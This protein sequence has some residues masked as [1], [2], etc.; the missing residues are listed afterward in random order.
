MKP[1]LGRPEDAEAVTRVIIDTMP[2]DPQWD[3][4]FPYCCEYPDDHYKYTKM[5]FEYFLDPSY[6]DWLVMVIED[7]LELGGPLT[8]VSFGVWD[9]SY[10]NKRRYGSSYKPQDCKSF[11]TPLLRPPIPINTQQ[12]WFWLRNREATPGE[13]PTTSAST[14]F[15]MVRLGRI[16][17]SLPQLALSRCISRFSPP[18][19]TSSGGATHQPCV[20]GLWIW[21][22]KS[23]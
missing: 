12:L 19:L 18:C 16:T 14:S 23:S 17:S 10:V 1:R 11:P 9:V 22:A 21:S 4:R 2:L 6:D 8:V 5:L 20:S 13:T 7:S 3:Y 15:G